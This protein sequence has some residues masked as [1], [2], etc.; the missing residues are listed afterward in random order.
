MSCGS[1]RSREAIP[2]GAQQVHIVVADAEVRLEPTKVRAG[3]V[4][5]VLEAPPTG[6]IV[7]LQRK[8]APA[9]A[10]GPL[11]DEDLARLAEGDTEGTQMD[12]IDAGGCSAEQDA[13][14][15]GLMGPCGNVFN[16]TLVVGKYAIFGATPEV[17]PAS[18]ES[19]P[20]IAIFEVVP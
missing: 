15:R 5:L 18:G 6:S 10:P 20:P 3:A 11:S 7:P 17:D 9:E 12:G 13:E 4:Y 8:R 14:D 16:V 19:A 2:P 1:D